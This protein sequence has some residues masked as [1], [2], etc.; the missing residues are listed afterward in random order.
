MTTK[1]NEEN[2]PDCSTAGKGFARTENC[3]TASEDCCLPFGGF[4]NTD[5]G[6]QDKVEQKDN[7]KLNC[8]KDQ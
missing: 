1:N 4:G 2:K 7:S 6:K 5:F 8:S 3:H